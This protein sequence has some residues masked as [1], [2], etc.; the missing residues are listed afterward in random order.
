[1]YAVIKGRLQYYSRTSIQLRSDVIKIEQYNHHR[2]S[3]L[4]FFIESVL[5]KTISHYLLFFYCTVGLM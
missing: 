4:T 3:I 2:N 1:M 5:K